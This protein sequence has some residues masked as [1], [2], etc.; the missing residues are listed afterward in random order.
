MNRE[1]RI[2]LPIEIRRALRLEPDVPL[3]V[4]IVG[5]KVVLTPLVAF[6][7]WLIEALDPDA[8]A[9]YL[10]ASRPDPTHGVVFENLSVEDLIALMPQEEQAAAHAEVARPGWPDDVP[11]ASGG[12]G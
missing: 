4:S 5:G 1:G 6:P 12:N 8:L 3:A 11:G 2:T 10:L 9:R 7:R